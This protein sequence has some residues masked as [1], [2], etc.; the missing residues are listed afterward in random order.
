MIK[1]THFALSSV[2]LNSNFA[3][4]SLATLSLGE[5]SLALYDGSPMHMCGFWPRF[6]GVTHHRGKKIWCS[7]AANQSVCSPSQ[8]GGYTPPAATIIQLKRYLLDLQVGSILLFVRGCKPLWFA[9]VLHQIF[10][11]IV[12][13]TRRR[14]WI[15]GCGPMHDCL[16]NLAGS[17]DH[18]GAHGAGDGQCRDGPHWDAR[19]QVAP[20]QCVVCWQRIW[21]ID[22][23]DN[24][25]IFHFHVIVCTNI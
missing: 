11:P 12:A 6:G 2:F 15:S 25:C 8:K 5:Q 4:F 16:E 9:A 20:Q 19:L 3:R 23:H 1:V 17:V 21:D 7:T 13:P 22:G 24:I 10:F 18:L 14:C